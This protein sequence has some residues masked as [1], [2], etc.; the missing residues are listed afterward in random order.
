MWPDRTYGLIWLCRRGKKSTVDKIVV[1]CYFATMLAS[2]RHVIA[3]F[4][5]AFNDNIFRIAFGTVL[6]A[7]GAATDTSTVADLSLAFMVPFLL[8]APTTGALGDRLPRDTIVRLSR[9]LEP[10]VIVLGAIALGSGSL[11]LMM[12]TMIALGAQS[13]LFG[14]VKYAIVPQLTT[15]SQL[16]AATGLLQAATGM[17]ILLG[18]AAAGLVDPGMR[19]WIGVAEPSPTLIVT[20]LALPVSLYAW[21]IVRRMPRL[22]AANPQR[23]IDGPWQFWPLL[24]PLGQTPGIIGPVAGLAGFWALGAVVNVTSLALAQRYLELGELGAAGLSVAMGIGMAVGA[25]LA[26][27]MWLPSRP[28]ALVAVGAG[29]AGLGTMVLAWCA[30]TGQELVAPLAMEAGNSIENGPNNDVSTLTIGAFAG[31]IVAGIGGGMWQ[32]P[33]NVALQRR[34]PADQR[35]AVFAGMGWI[36]NLALVGGFQLTGMMVPWL[37]DATF[38]FLVGGLVSIGA[39]VALWTWRWAVLQWL[40]SLLLRLRYR[41]DVANL[42]PLPEQGGRLLVCNH[43]SFAD[44]VLLFIALP[45]PVRFIIHRQY[46]ENPWYGWL[47]RGIG[48]IPIDGAGSRR[49]LIAAIKAATAACQRGETVMIFPEGALTRS[50]G[51]NPVGS[52]ATR[53]ATAAGIPVIPIGLDGLTGSRWSKVP[54]IRTWGTYLRRRLVTIT[55]EAALEEPS[56]HAIQAALQRCHAASFSRRLP[57]K[58]LGQALVAMA[59]RAPNATLVTDQTASITRIRAVA[60]ALAMPM[61][62]TADRVGVL[63]PPGRGGVIVNFALALR[64]QTAVNLNHTVGAA[65]LAKMCELAGIDTIISSTQ[66]IRKGNIDT[67][68]TVRVVPVEDLLGSLRGKMGKLKQ[69]WCLLRAYLQPWLG[70]GNPDTTAAI[71]FSSG[72]TGTP[73]GIQLSH[74]NILANVRMCVEHLRLNQHR[75]HDHQPVLLNSLPLFHSFGLTVGCWLGATTTMGTAAYPDPRDARGIGAMAAQ[76]NATFLVTTPT[77]AR[78][79]LRR[80]EPEQFASMEFIVLGAEKCPDDLA[81]ALQERFDVETFE[82][83]G[84]TEMGPVVTCNISDVDDGIVHEKHNRI[85]TVGR[86]LPGVT[87]QVVDPATFEPVKPNAEGIAN[88]LLLLTSPARMQGYLNDPDKTAAALRGEA[89]VSGDIASIDPQGFISLTGRLSRFAK[90]GGEMVPLDAVQEALQA[91]APTSE[92]GSTTLAVAAV[93]DAQKSERLVVVYTVDLDPQLLTERCQL[94]PIFTPKTRD[95][96]QVPMIPVLGTGK[97]DLAGLSTLAK[98]VSKK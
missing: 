93:P 28:H 7:R 15:D 77:F 53:I 83:Y 12:A 4:V 16:P 97:L 20:S 87:A 44:G 13:A 79:Y 90:I 26:P 3:S 36:T 82:G 86:P 31:A 58:T 89:Y 34:A 18:T 47:L 27:R 33:L 61:P 22:E 8:L 78:A 67:P 71:I 63:L 29:L 42:T 21:F 25:F 80:V 35:S 19:T 55:I 72:S 85:G 10:F 46:V 68:D 49:A 70:Q 50:G 84:A 5:G 32:V 39:V 94:P 48:A 57:E 96:H 95:W 9:L 14:P 69:L 75:P 73:K 81:K 1:V 54:V 38:V 64:G 66:Y 41:L 74:R 17:A 76:E 30:G 45:C 65:H 11:P 92:D 59:R 91:L 40:G 60:G 51:I 62:T 24:K 6:T 2:T 37:G 56:Q 23:R 88:G 52:G 98:D 43:Q